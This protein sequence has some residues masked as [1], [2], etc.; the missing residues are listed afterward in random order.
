ML[1]QRLR[2][3]VAL[4]GDDVDNT[5]GNI[6]RIKH[7]IEISRRQRLMRRRHSHHAVAHGNRRYHQRDKA[8]Q[9][10]LVGADEAHDAPGLVHGERHV[11]GF[12]GVDAAIIFVCLGGIPEDAGK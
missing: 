1:G 10:H 7:L 3:L 6:R 5:A 11:A 8:Q 2:K 12:G 9:R 4:A